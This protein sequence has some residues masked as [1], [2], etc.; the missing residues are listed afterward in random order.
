MRFEVEVYR[1]EAGEWIA[2][3]IEYKITAKGM[4]ENEAL[5]RVMEAL[6]KHFKA[7]G[8]SSSARA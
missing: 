6:A 8:K 3:A 5:G 1:T 7:V 2:E 4:T